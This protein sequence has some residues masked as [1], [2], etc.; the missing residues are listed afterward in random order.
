[1]YLKVRVT[2]REG[3]GT[4]GG[5]GR[6]KK[7]EGKKSSIC[8]L[9]SQKVPLAGAVPSQ[10]PVASSGFPTRM[11]HPKHSSCFLRHI[12]REWGWKWSSWDLKYYYPSGMLALHL[13]A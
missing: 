10:E 3:K 7:R 12:S 6:E 2:D 9:A 5:G 4:K 11:Q 1:M 8:W 13:E